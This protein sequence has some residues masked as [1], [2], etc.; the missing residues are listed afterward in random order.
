[1]KN[2]N[3]SRFPH[4]P[5]ASVPFHPTPSSFRRHDDVCA[6]K[7]HFFC[8]P[9]HRRSAKKHFQPLFCSRLCFPIK[10]TVFLPFA[11]WRGSGAQKICEKFSRVGMGSWD[12]TIMRNAEARLIRSDDQRVR[13]FDGV[14]SATDDL[15]SITRR[16]FFLPCVTRRDPVRSAIISG[17]QRPRAKLWKLSVKL[18]I[19]SASTVRHG[20]REREN[21]KCYGSSKQ[22]F[23]SLTTST[24]GKN[25]SP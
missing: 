2:V 24:V 13:R 18:K 22:I 17:R 1:M 11:V 25:E 14:N 15:K 3:Y 12:S 23:T 19:F 6:M 21:T 20:E 8:L 10:L 4:F 16:L 9:V 7:K 5:F